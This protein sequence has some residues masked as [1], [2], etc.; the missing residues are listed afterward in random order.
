M[1]FSAENELMICAIE[2]PKIVTAV[3]SNAKN[4]LNLCFNK[5][6]KPNLKQTEYFKRRFLA[7]DFLYSFKD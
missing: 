2:I 5:L 3:T 7:V 4:D 6:F 1:V